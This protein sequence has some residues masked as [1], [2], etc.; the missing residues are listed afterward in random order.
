M[1][2]SVPISVVLLVVAAAVGICGYF[3]TRTPSGP[4]DAPTVP[5]GTGMTLAEARQRKKDTLKAQDEKKK[6]A[7][8]K[9]AEKTAV[10]PAKAESAP[11]K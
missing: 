3:F 10:T 7:T 8:A 9:E 2:K 6:A 1:K 4:P 5:K 11:S